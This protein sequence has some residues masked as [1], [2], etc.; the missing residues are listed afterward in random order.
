MPSGVETF[1]D[2]G[3][4]TIDFVD[5]SLRGQGLAK[6][7]EIGGPESVETITRD[8]P[9]RKYRVPEGNATEAGLLDNR[10]DATA[11]GDLKFASALAAADPIAEGG[12][13]RPDMP[14]GQFAND[15]P[16]EQ[17]LVAGNQSVRTTEST[18]PAAVDAVAPAH[19]EVIAKVKSNAAARRKPAPPRKRAGK[20]GA[21]T[22]AAQKAAQ[23]SDP[24]SRPEA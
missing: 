17:A 3:F 7:I 15:R 14:T 21:P 12:T 16:V 4:A 13:F 2:D 10:V 19:V 5:P 23:G 18:D 6:L 20:S 9:R 1:V 8:G 24:Q 11:R 22:I